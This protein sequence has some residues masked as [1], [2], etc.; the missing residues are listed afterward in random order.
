[1]PPGPKAAQIRRDILNA[2]K[3]AAATAASLW[4]FTYI[5]SA[6]MLTPDPWFTAAVRALLG[7][8]PLLLLSRELPPAHFWPRLIV[9][10]SLNA[11]LFFSLLFIAAFRLP[12]GVAGT[13]QALSPLFSAV[14]VWPLLGQRPTVLGIVSLAVG[15]FGVALVVLKSSAALDPLGIAAALGCALSIALGGVLLQ[16][17]RQ[18]MT[19][20]GFT[21]WQLMIAGVELSVVA[22]MLGDIPASLT[23][24]NGLGL[25]IVA[26]ALTSLPFVLW[27]RAIK[28]EGAAGVAPFLLLTPIVAFALDTLIRNIVPSPL[29]G[30]GVL[31]VIIGLLM[32]ILVGRR[33]AARV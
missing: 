18:P 5:V 3:L 15:V 33:P 21:A 13:F 17:W 7:A 8:L 16:K 10:G 30:L 31:F 27:F 19:L 32:N 20:T 25:A 24:M 2:N 11:G 29:Q 1:M 14:L 6:T 26:F 28:G 9:L 4:G 23:P 22:V 12:G